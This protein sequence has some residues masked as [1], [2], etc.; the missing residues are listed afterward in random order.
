MRRFGRKAMPFAIGILTIA[1]L[2]LYA[3]EAPSETDHPSL[4]EWEWF[5]RVILPEAPATT[6]YFSLIVPP[7]VFDKA[8]IAFPSRSDD[9]AESFSGPIKSSY[10]PKKEPIELQDL[11]LVDQ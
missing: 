7:S 1:T 3:Q 11:R 8:K 2:P 4:A 5:E 10:N 6:R 9:Q